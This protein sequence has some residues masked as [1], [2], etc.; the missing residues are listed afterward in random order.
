MWIVFRSNRSIAM[1][2]SQFYPVTK[3]EQIVL[4]FVIDGIHA[5]HEHRNRILTKLAN[6]GLVRAPVMLMKPENYH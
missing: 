2:T 4:P 1:D 5:Q 3:P 6:K